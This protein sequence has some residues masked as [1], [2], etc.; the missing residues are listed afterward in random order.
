MRY[1]YYMIATRLLFFPFFLSQ[2]QASLLSFT[3]FSRAGHSF[4]SHDVHPS[5]R[6]LY[7]PQLYTLT[8]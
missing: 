3:L 8:Y 2:Q 6:M 4:F 5:T 7:P 1:I